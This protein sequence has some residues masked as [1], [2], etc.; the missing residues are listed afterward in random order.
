MRKPTGIRFTDDEYKA[1][2]S[3]AV[4]HNT[5]F[6][7]VV[8]RATHEFL[9]PDRNKGYLTLAQVTSSTNGDI[10]LA[11][12]QFLDDFAHAKDKAALIAD[13]PMWSKEE[14]GRWYYD[15]AATAHKLANDNKLPVPSWCIEERYCPAEPL[16]AFDTKNPEFQ[17]YLRET[18][19]REFR[20]HNLFLGPN[21][22]QRA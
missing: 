11:F 19:P 5:S 1:I 8:R 15:L 2:A 22:L 3:Y 21:I 18:T 20:W 14:A 10:A 7:D 13:E 12:G 4:K 9:D 16:W 17:A 6:S